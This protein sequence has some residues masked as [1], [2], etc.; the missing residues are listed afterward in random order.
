MADA[1]VQQHRRKKPPPLSINEDTSCVLRAQDIEKIRIW[2]PPRI[3][4]D[5]HEATSVDHRSNKGYNLQY[6]DPNR[7]R[8]HKSIPRALDGAAVPSAWY[9]EA[10]AEAEANRLPRCGAFSEKLKFA[11]DWI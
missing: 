4:G 1:A 2:T 11:P 8:E 7:E 5:R 9:H 3:I 10:G 6:A